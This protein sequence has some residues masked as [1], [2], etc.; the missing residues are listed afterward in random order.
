MSFLKPGN[1]SAIISPDKFSSPFSL[2]YSAGT[3]IMHILV[4]LMVSYKSLRLFSFFFIL[5]S[6]C[7]SDSIISNNL[8]SN[9]LILSFVCSGLLLNHSNEF[10]YL[11]TMFLSSRILVLFF[12]IISTSLSIFSFCS[13]IIFLV[14]P[15]VHVL[16]ENI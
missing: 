13:H 14:C 6:F 10:F 5:F 11:V 1:F 12:F 15:S 9:S 7:C 3:C 4:C 2:C 16:F 8:N